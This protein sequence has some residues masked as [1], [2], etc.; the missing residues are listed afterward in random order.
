MF[1]MAESG[2]DSM[3]WRNR[4]PPRFLFITFVDVVIYLHEP[5]RP[6]S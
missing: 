5:C 3:G 4:N 6:A 2:P 1:D